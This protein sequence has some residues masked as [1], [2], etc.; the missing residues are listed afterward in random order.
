MVDIKQLEQEKKVVTQ[1]VQRTRSWYKTVVDASPSGILIMNK[2]GNIIFC[3]NMACQ[4]IG[5]SED[6]LIN[7]PIFDIIP[8]DRHEDLIKRTKDIIRGNKNYDSTPLTIV[9][10]TGA[11]I[12][13]EGSATIYKNEAGQKEGIIMIFNDVT[14]R[15]QQAKIIQQQI[16]DLNA[17]NEELKKYIDSNL[18]LENFAYI[19]S[20]DL[21]APIRSVISF[22]KLLTDSAN[23]NLSEKENKFLQIITDS[24]EHM[25]EL[26]D[27]LLIFSRVNTSNTILDVVNIK[28]MID[29]ILSD[30]QQDI[31]KYDA[32]IETSNLPQKII[33]DKTKIRQVFQNLIANGMKFQ[34][35]GIKPIVKISGSKIKNY[36]SFEISDNGIGIDQKHIDK[37]FLLFQKLHSKDKYEGSGMGLAISKKVIEQHNGTIYAKNHQDRGCTIGFTISDKLKKSS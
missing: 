8:E 31:I 29:S 15:V 20:H 6:Q 34:G 33:A 3:S 12:N 27:D 19:A 18:Q 36:W 21:K 30:L 14:E 32:T 5:V 11:E 2:S 13:I 37:I 9:P 24:S 23:E 16:K 28:E 17:K 10:G 1:D 7:R 35:D 4:I 26:I 22:A 25:R